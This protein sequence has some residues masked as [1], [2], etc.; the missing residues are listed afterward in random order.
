M[1]RVSG[2]S[3]VSASLQKGFEM[4]FERDTCNMSNKKKLNRPELQTVSVPSGHYPPRLLTLAACMLRWQNTTL[5]GSYR[6]KELFVSCSS[7]GIWVYHSHGREHGSRHA[8]MALAEQLRAQ[9]IIDNQEAWN[10]LKIDLAFWTLKAYPN[11]RPSPTRP[12]LL[13]LPK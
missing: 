12:H 1:K 9:V 6:R 13:I 8:D 3:R 7:R 11:D 10:T 4:S 5:K 2:I